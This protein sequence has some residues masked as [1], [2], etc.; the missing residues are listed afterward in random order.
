MSAK[1]SSRI[2]IPKTINLTATIKT[3]VVAE[4]R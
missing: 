1:I 3:K 4:L 2:N